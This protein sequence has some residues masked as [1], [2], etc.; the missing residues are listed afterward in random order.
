M[1]GTF[2]N[3]KKVGKKSIIHGKWINWFSDNGWSPINPNFQ[4]DRQVTDIPFCVES[5]LDSHGTLSLCF[6][7]KWSMRRRILGDTTL[8]N[9][10]RPFNLEIIA[11]SP[12]NITGHQDPENPNR[13]IYPEAWP[14]TT[15]RYGIWHGRIPRLEKV[16][17]IDPAKFSS[18][19]DLS[20][21]FILRSNTAVT[22]VGGVGGPR[23]WAGSLGDQAQ[24][25]GFNIYVSDNDS[26]LRGATL[27]KPVCWWYRDGFPV[28]KDITVIAEILGSGDQVRLTKKIPASYLK[29]AL[30]AGSKLWSDITVSPDPHPESSSYDGWFQNLV[31]RSSWAVRRTFDWEGGTVDN[32]D[33]GLNGI[34]SSHLDWRQLDRI[35]YGFDL[36]GETITVGSATFENTTRSSSTVSGN[37][38]HRPQHLVEHNSSSN[39]SISGSNYKLADW[40]SELWSDLVTCSLSSGQKNTF[41]LTSAG[42]AAVNAAIGVGNIQFGPLFD[43][44]MADTPIPWTPIN[45][46][47]LFCYI[48]SHQ[49][50]ASGT[51]ND[52]VLTLTEGGGGGG[53]G[54]E[55]G[56][57]VIIRC[58]SGMSA[59]SGLS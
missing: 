48:Y 58:M 24:I 44:E 35:T 52:P 45:G 14:N 50:E 13:W 10:E 12:S 39:T 36:S 3:S 17:E 5:P 11:E 20:Y 22:R 25:K 9:P 55:V 33:Y 49:S 46:Q 51:S 34:S 8:S 4:S 41:T 26:E 18:L 38:D 37:A 1:S 21:S 57:S 19:K 6:D 53:E 56:Q 2:W 59:L 27:K 23:P 30:D 7:H 15:L 32:S 31:V 47:N 29:E 28:V 40:G 43:S 54:E 16:L 42:I